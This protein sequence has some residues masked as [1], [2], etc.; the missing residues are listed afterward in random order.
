MLKKTADPVYFIS[1]NFCQMGRTQGDLMAEAAARIDTPQHDRR[2][3]LRS[4]GSS[5]ALPDSPGGNLQEYAHL[6]NSDRLFVTGW[7]SRGS[8]EFSL[9]AQWPAVHGGRRCDPRVLAQT[10][11]QS[12]LVITHAEYGVPLSHQMLLHDFNFTVNP[13]FNLPQNR[14]TDLDIDV[15]VAGT[16]PSGRVGSALDMKLHIRQGQTTVAHADFQCAWSSPAA[17]RRLRGAHLGVD[18]GSWTLPAPVAPKLVGRSSAADVVLA[19]SDRPRRWQLRNDTGNTLLFDHPVDHV[20]GLALLE[21][22]YQAAHATIA[23]AGFDPTVFTSSFARYVEFDE[24]CWIET[25]LLPRS[26]AGPLAVQVTG[27]QGGRTVFRAG[28]SGAPLPGAVR[29]EQA[30]EG[31]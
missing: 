27:V 13:E 11:R 30:P 6:K 16:G 3:P 15:T 9:T 26:A 7:N 14:P 4:D 31:H 29:R 25:E 10:I 1:V 20:P 19:A 2:S 21:A 17:Y 28:L 8:G 5:G 12:G 23:P 24:P 18:W 22:A